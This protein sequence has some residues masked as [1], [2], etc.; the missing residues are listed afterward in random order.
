MKNAGLYAIAFKLLAND[1]SKFY[2]LLIGITFAV[3][4]MV[5]MTSMFAGMLDRSSA[6]VTNVGASIW[7]MDPAVQTVAN[8]IPMP[9]YVHRR[10]AQHGRSELRCAP[11]LGRRPR[12]LAD[13]TY[14]SVNIIGL[15]DT[16]LFGRPRAGGRADIED[17]YGENGFIVVA[18]RRIRKTRPP[19][20]GH[21]VRDQRP[22]GRHRR[23][24]Q[25]ARR[26]DCLAC[27]LSTRPQPRPAVHS[28]D[29]LHDVLHSCRTEEPR[30]PSPG[31]RRKWRSSA[32]SP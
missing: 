6:T 15:D 12:Q 32:T 16:S 13:G 24:R 22:P 14:Q 9:D 1:R 26:T 25:G 18:R 11:L 19:R 23:H 7:V 28:V 3:F 31:S 8:T 5:Q 20:P 10:R 27:P 17:I 2:S 21:R 4:L 29:A 30:P